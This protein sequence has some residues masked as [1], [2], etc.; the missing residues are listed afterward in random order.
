MPRLV[1]RYEP[2]QLKRF[3]VAQGITG[4]WQI[5]GRSDRPLHLHTE[6]DIYYV[7]NYSL[8]LHIQI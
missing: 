6:D 5:N 7:Y 8:W 1:A 4:W 2:W 3:A